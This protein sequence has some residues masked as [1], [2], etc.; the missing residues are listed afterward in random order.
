MN[1]MNR[2]WFK[3][4][5]KEL[6]N[7]LQIQVTEK[8]LF[9]KDLSKTFVI[10]KMTKIIW[11]EVQVDKICTPA[12]SHLLLPVS[13]TVAGAELTERYQFQ[14]QLVFQLPGLF[15]QIW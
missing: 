12:A 15:T 10:W 11:S 5:I 6:K 3:Y 9:I 13:A 14:V 2:I 4:L 7:L 8:K 1:Q